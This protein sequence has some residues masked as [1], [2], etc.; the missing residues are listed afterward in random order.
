MNCIQK[1]AEEENIRLDV[2]SLE[3]GSKKELVETRKSFLDDFGSYEVSLTVLTQLAYIPVAAAMLMTAYMEPTPEWCDT[4]RQSGNAWHINDA[5]EFYSISVQHG[6]ACHSSSTSTVYWMTSCLM[7][8]ALFGSFICGYLSD[9]YGRK[10]ICVGCLFMVT[11]SHFVLVLSMYLYWKMIYV[12]AVFM[13][14]FCGGYMVTNFV[15]LTESYE[16][17]RSR[18]LVVSFNGWS[19]A[20]AITALL[21][22][23]TLHW[24]HYHLFFGVIG[25]CLSLMLYK[26]SYESCRWLSAKGRSDEAKLIA[27]RITLCNNQKRLELEEVDSMEWY[28]ILGFSAP[29]HNPEKK[30]WKTLFKSFSKPTAVM[31]Y[32]FLASSIVSFGF[33]FSI[34]ILP[35]NRYVN[36]G[37]MGLA[38]FVLGFFPF[39]LNKC[40]T[41]RIIAIVSIAICCFASIAVVLIQYIDQPVWRPLIAVFS[42]TVSAGIDPTWKI[43]HLYSAELFPTSVRSMARGVCNAGGR[44]GSVLAPMIVYFR[45]I[46]LLIPNIVFTVLLL[47]QLVVIVICLPDDSDKDANEMNDE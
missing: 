8:G 40:V 26:C 31:C 39:F 23:A 25:L 15:L 1:M 6:R 32:S 33:Y 34:D 2:S 29:T 13:G 20:M 30:T 35:G 22:R 47:I 3:S 41:K 42:L 44:L 7:W 19:L 28:E 21:A 27:T 14:F 46:N 10:P 16:L 38:K 36:M 37:F 11:L 17:A 9:R 24:Y 5:K 43:N 12:V 18:L 4:T 45:T